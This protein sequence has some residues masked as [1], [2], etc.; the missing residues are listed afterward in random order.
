[1]PRKSKVITR[2]QKAG[3]TPSKR[4]AQKKSSSAAPMPRGLSPMAQYVE[5]NQDSGISV[6]ELIHQFQEYDCE[7][8]KVEIVAS[9]SETITER[10]VTCRRMNTKPRPGVK[11]SA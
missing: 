4:R 5:D 2:Y 6:L 8:E 1:M 9:S 7:H 3:K 10:C 11:K